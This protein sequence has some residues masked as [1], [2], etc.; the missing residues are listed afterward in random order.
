ME[1]CVIVC[2][3]NKDIKLLKLKS[4][5][6]NVFGMCQIIVLTYKKIADS[7]DLSVICFDKKTTEDQAL[8]FAIKKCKMQN[9]LI[10]RNSYDLTKILELAQLKDSAQKGNQIVHFKTQTT[11]NQNWLTKIISKLNNWLLGY[12]NYDNNISAMLF[13]KSP[14]NVLQ[15]V[16]NP[17]TFTKINCWKGFKIQS[18]EN[19]NISV[20]KPNVKH[21]KQIA[22]FASLILAFIADITLLIIFSK[23]FFVVCVCIVLLIGLVLFALLSALQLVNHIAV[24]D[25]M[26]KIA[27]P[28]K[29]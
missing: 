19:N 17:A 28:I 26:S 16:V 7:Q 14:T 21:T 8:N 29:K 13:S 10:L 22:V 4:K 27:Q 5:I 24:G 12:K 15:S 1:Y 23:S 18:I 6:E 2:L 25:I 11:R 20:F 3:L 9:L